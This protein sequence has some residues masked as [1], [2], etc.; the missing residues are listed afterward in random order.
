M[1][2]K[3]LTLPNKSSKDAKTDPRLGLLEY[4]NTPVDGFRSPA[5][6]LKGR[7]LRSIMPC[8]T[9]HLSPKTVSPAELRKVRQMQQQR[10]S[11]YYDKSAAP[12]P[13]LNAGQLIWCQLKEKGQWE[14]AVIKSI[15]DSRSYWIT[16]ENG[17]EYRR[18]RVHL[19]PRVPSA[20]RIVPTHEAGPAH[21]AAQT[22]CSAT[23]EPV[24]VPAR[25]TATT[26]QDPA[27]RRSSVREKKAVIRLNL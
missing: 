8:T 23:A 10:Q 20:A 13:P 27:L 26:S 19:R 1:P 15:H 11:C 4:R 25:T 12:L 2:K 21:Q 6:L 24:A 7:Q 14:K 5:Q 3:P 17:G 9:R 16:T 18:N 22:G